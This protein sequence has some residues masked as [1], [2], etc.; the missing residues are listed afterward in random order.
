M[1]HVRSTII[2]SGLTLFLGITLAA[3][4]G[5]GGAVLSTV[6]NAVGEPIGGGV[7]RAGYGEG[8]QPAASAAPQ[9][10]GDGVGALVDDAKIIRT[11]TIDIE[12]TDVPKA[13]LAAR[14]G[15]RSMGGYIGASQTANTDDRPTA[16]VTYR[17]P[18]DRWED[19]L[20]LLRGL[21][22]LTSKV[23]DE[24][25]EAVEV[26]GA[27]IDL[28][29]RIRNLRAS[30]T[31]LQEIAAGATKVSDVLEVQAQ[32]TSVR[33][34]IEQLTAQLGDLT[35]R[36][37]FATLTVSYSLPVVAVELARKGFEPGAVVDAASA[38]LVDILQALTTAGIW[39]AIVWLPILLV[40]GLIVALVTVVIRRLGWLGRRD[41]GDLPLPG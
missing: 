13:L 9:A 11:G 26:T 16:S 8:Q 38:S 37:S 29:A 35:D 1:F 32:L 20:D 7:D 39:F 6:G 33:G 25:T 21:N 34:Q 30:E 12:V 10:P 41:R 2:R 31:A 14:D 28:E 18:A 23:L 36:A 19:A 4:A 3:C 27:V 24:K 5:S 40:L 22:G 17:I 15:I